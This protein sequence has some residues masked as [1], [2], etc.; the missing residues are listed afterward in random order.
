MGLQFLVGVDVSKERLDLN[1]QPSKESFAVSYDQRGLERLIARLGQIPVELAR[2][3]WLRR[4]QR[5]SDQS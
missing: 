5:R 4:S 2:A 3:V 1:V